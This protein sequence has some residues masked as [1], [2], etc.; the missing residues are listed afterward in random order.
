M[1]K[2]TYTLLGILFAVGLNA[3]Q[4]TQTTPIQ[5]LQHIWN[6]AFTAPGTKMD[7]SAYYRRQWLGFNGAPSTAAASIQYPFVDMNMSAGAIIIAD[8]TGP[9]SKTGLQVNYA[10]KLKELLN[11]DDQLSFGINGYFHQYGFDADGVTIRDKDDVLLTSGRQ[12]KFVPSFGVGM[13][14]FSGTEDYSGDNIFFVG[15][16][17]LQILANDLLLDAGN[18]KRERHY[19]VNMGTRLFGYNHFIE[20]SF[21]VNY[22][23]PQLINYV[24]GAKF[25]LEESFWAGLSYSSVNDVAING[26]VILNE[27]AGRYT[28][29]KIGALATINGG[30]IMSAGTSF[31]FFVAYTI[32]MD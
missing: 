14:Y 22:V 23:N 29:L 1:K 5:D 30:S 2:I 16:S 8:R 20:P 28:Q 31:E 12:T 24:L 11:R 26:G 6:P 9:V 10:Y 19:F 18:A 13:A 7:V 4:L 27:I 21:Q 15:F 3:Q 32:D 17:A 25:E